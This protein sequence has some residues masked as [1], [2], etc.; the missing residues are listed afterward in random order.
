M[1]FAY[2]SDETVR[3]MADKKNAARTDESTISQVNILREYC[4]NTGINFPE[5]TA[6]AADLNSMP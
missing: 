3:M 5:N 4:Q 6:T 1:R 2:V